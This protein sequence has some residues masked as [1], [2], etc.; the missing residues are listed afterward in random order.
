MLVRKILTTFAYYVESK[1][2][3]RIFTK[4]NSKSDFITLDRFSF[5]NGLV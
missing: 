5:L 1:F 2:D 4:L 3:K